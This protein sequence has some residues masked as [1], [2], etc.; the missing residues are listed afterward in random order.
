MGVA[1]MGKVVVTAKIEN[2]EDKYKAH[3]GLIPPDQVRTLFVDDAI[4]DTGASG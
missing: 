1:T 4:V 3:Q 2:L